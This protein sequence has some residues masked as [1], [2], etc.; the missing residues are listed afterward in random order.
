[1][2][3]G[4]TVFVNTLTHSNSD[5]FSNKGRSWSADA[6]DGLACR[7]ESASAAEV[8]K[9]K[10]LGMTVSHLVF[11]SADQGLSVNTSR[12]HWTKTNGNKTTVD[13]ILRV[14]GT[15]TENNPRGRLILYVVTCN[16]ETERRDV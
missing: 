7:V 13:K 2:T 9:Y 14:T 8:Q 3:R 1:M 12:L 5:A 11:F 6:G 16:F 15:E 10:A 4:D